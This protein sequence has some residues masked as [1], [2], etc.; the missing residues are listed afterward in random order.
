MSYSTPDAIMSGV[1]NSIGLD[2]ASFAVSR[3]DSIVIGVVVVVGGDLEVGCHIYI[4]KMVNTIN[5]LQIY[6]RSRK[7]RHAMAPTADSMRKSNL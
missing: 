5:K 1:N 6:L 4:Y 7:L 2:A 3:R